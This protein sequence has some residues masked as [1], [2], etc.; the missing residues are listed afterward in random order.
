MCTDQA[1]TEQLH[2]VFLIH[3]VGLNLSFK[4]HNEFL[5]PLQWA[6]V[7]HLLN[8]PDMKN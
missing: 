7:T 5:K 8:M 1:D 3:H 6:F 4:T 2:L